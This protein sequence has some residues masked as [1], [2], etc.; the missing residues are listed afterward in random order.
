MAFCCRLVMVFWWRV[1]L[2][3]LRCR[4]DSQGRPEARLAFWAGWEFWEFWE[5]W[6]FWECWGLGLLGRFWLGLVCVGSAVVG[7]CCS[8]LCGASGSPC[9]V[10]GCTFQMLP[11][12]LR[13]A[14][15]IHGLADGFFADEAEVVVKRSASLEQFLEAALLICTGRTPSGMM[16]PRSWL[17]SER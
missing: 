1:S 16:T 10:R 7:F 14:G 15:L 4:G 8:R 17:S 2:H 5:N 11:D 13:V 6:E 9:L 3:R 12:I